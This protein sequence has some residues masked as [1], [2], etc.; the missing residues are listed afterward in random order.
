M[1]AELEAA[2]FRQVA[3]HYITHAVE[4][5]DVTAF[6]A[7]IRRTLAPLVLLKKQVGEEAF[8]SIEEAIDARLAAIAGPGSVRVTMPAWIGVGTA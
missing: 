1:R 7:S 6:S 3:A 8:R 5:P 4:H 2:G